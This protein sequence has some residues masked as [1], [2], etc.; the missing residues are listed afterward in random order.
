MARRDALFAPWHEAATGEPIL[1]RTTSGEPSYWL[2]P[3]E[4]L[5]RAIG[6]VRVALDGAVSAAGAFYRR[7]DELGACPPVV[8]GITAE[9]AVSAVVADIG[10]E[11]TALAAVFVHDGPPGR[12]AWLVAGGGRRFFVTRGGVR[13]RPAGSG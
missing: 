11:R 12:E 8:T 10:I 4:A 5:G 1:V 6:F 7:P 2:V 3:V 9:D 13:E